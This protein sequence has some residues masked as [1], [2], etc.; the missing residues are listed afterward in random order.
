M[1][2]GNGVTATIRD[3]AD[4]VAEKVQDAADGMAAIA[5]EAAKRV[6]ASPKKTEIGR[7]HV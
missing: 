6:R 3:A 5:R 4:A 7:A 2:N 1:S